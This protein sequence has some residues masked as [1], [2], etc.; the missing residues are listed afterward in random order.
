[1]PDTVTL[2]GESEKIWN[3]IK[4]IQLDLFGLPDQTIEKVCIP[5]DVEPSSLYIQSNVGAVYAALETVLS[6]N[7]SI[8]MVGKFWVIARKAA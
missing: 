8:E 3:E 6:K 5:V 4:D 2:T 7:F 1:M